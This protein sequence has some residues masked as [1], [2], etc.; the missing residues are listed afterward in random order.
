[1]GA[2]SPSYY[3]FITKFFT[4]CVAIVNSEHTIIHCGL[5][6]VIQ[7]FGA[8]INRVNGRESNFYDC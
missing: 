7:L 8:A 1:M 4:S 2:I 6:T 5:F 3:L